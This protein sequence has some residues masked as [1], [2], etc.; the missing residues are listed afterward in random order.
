MPYA[1]A[2]SEHPVPAHATG[3]VI[4]E[5]LDRVGTAP[6]LVSVFVTPP[7]AGALDDI[8]RTIRSVLNPRVLVGSSA[9]SVLGG[10]REV[11]EVAAVSLFAGRFGVDIT[12]ARL[13]AHEGIDGEV[14]LAGGGGVGHTGTLL[15]LADPFTFPTPTILDAMTE[16]AP[17]LKVVGGMASAARGPGGNVLVL[18][19]ETFR[20]GAVG[21]HIP[22]S[23]P[24][25]PV[26]SQGCRPFGQPFVVT[27]SEGNVI[28][29]LAGR[30]ALERL[31]EQIEALSPDDR[32]LAAEGL[33]AGVVIDERRTSFGPGDFLIRAVLGADREVGAVAIG[34]DVEPGTT[35]QFQVRD[36]N[37]ATHELQTLMSGRHAEGA[38]VFTCNGRGSRLFGVPDHDASLISES[39]NGSAVSGMFCAGEIGPVG[40][41]NFVHG[42]TASLALFSEPDSGRIA[43]H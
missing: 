42:F 9:V 2:L 33:H 25:T 29:E 23:V 17:D 21:V 31:M 8:I 36:A 35:V 41:R 11:E 38:L 14:L 5:I 24:V 15:L 26:I 39:L 12:P 28:R 1:A 37:S 19:D 27:R 4:G 6:D 22:D 16:N 43:A 3:E 32:R 40:G 34:A 7:F 30:P 18:D 13:L 20:D 10:S